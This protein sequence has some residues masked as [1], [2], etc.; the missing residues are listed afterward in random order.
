MTA[1]PPPHD[2][3][4]RLLLWIGLLSV[5]AS[6]VVRVIHRGPFISGWDL[7]APSEGAFLASTGSFWSALREVFHHNRHH[8]NPFSEYS[9]V[10][11]LIPGYLE[12]LWPWQYWVHVL[13]LISFVLALRVT[14]RATGMPLRRG[15]ILL[16]GWGASPV[17]L[18]LAVTGFPWASAFVPHA[19]ALWITMSR[20]LR[21]RWLVTLALTL[22]TIELSMHVYELGKTAGSVF[23]V[24]A[25]LQRHVP[26]WTRAIWLIGGLGQLV[27]AVFVFPSSNFPAFGIP[28]DATGAVMTSAFLPGLRTMLTSICNWDVDLP[29]LLLAGALS[30]FFFRRD[31]W[32]LLALLLA[33]LTGFLLLAMSGAGFVRPRRFLLVSCYCLVALASM[34]REASPLPR[35]A[36]VALLLAGNVWQGMNLRQFVR[37]PFP[38]SDQAFTLPYVQSLEGVGLVAFPYVEWSRDLRARVEGGE[39]LLLLYNFGCYHENFTNPAGVLERLYLSL[40]HERFAQSVF[41]FGSVNCRYD[42]LPIRPL[43]QF[44]SFLDGVRPDGPTPPATLGVYTVTDCKGQGVDGADVTQMLATIARRF[45]VPLRG[46]REVCAPHHRG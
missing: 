7:V 24:G 32:F 38:S 16:L 10:Y 27:Q 28:R 42:C 19:L 37:T 45:R 35:R 13:T 39:R 1:G 15:G 25:V 31:R 5:S 40:G 26:L 29:I 17:L 12:R 21:R 33:Q 46:R 34:Y 20:R 18:S 22:L 11:S 2:R 6:L 36:L 9:A 44:E 30:F 14:L 3:E 8:W 41:V 4:D 23:V 43:E